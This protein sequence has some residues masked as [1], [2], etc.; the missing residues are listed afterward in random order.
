MLWVG[1]AMTVLI[2]AMWLLVV[3]YHVRAV[4]RRRMMMPGLD[5]DKG[6][7][8]LEDEKEG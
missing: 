1:S 7:S 5:E 8:D 2:A 3:F 4:L 6:E